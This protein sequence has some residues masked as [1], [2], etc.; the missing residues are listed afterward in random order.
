M[1]KWPGRMNNGNHPV[2]TAESQV[3]GRGAW[4]ESNRVPWSNIKCASLLIVGTLVGEE[5]KWNQNVF[6]EIMAENIPNLKKEIDTQVQG[7]QRVANNLNPNRP[8]P[9]R[10]I[11][12]M[13]E[14]KDWILKVAREKVDYKGTPT[15]L[16]TD[17]SAGMAAG[18]VV[19]R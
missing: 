9:R 7:S 5:R 11:I 19:A 13:T 2:R 6:E 14:V 1:N 8:T 12:Q 3:G 4:S 18:K 10:S 15:R 16:S 17:F